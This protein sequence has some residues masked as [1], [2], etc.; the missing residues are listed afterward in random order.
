MEAAIKNMAGM[1]G[2]RKVLILGDMFEL[3]GEAEA[4]H[5]NIG[6]LIRELGFTE[7]YLCGKL[8]SSA[9]KEFPV[10]KHFYSK[11]ELMEALRLNPVT[12]ATVLVKAS[13]G[14]G[15]DTVTAL[16]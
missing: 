4:E 2:S 15:L 3:E 1:K 7:V 13:R 10:A 11:E 9:M 6:K 12:H 5:R 14:M 8:M 16:L